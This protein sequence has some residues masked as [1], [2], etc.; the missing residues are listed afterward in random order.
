VP[1]IIKHAVVPVPAVEA[2]A[3]EPPAVVALAVAGL[4]V[5]ALA[6]EAV[7]AELFEEPLLPQAAARSATAPISGTS[8]A[9]LTVDPPC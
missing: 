7:V 8:A 6:L 3:L 2:L 4:A 1:S 5:D 9:R